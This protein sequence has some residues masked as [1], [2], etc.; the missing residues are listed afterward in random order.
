MKRRIE[1]AMTTDWPTSTPLMPAKMLIALVQNTASMPMYTK[2]RT[3][4]GAERAK[5]ACVGGRGAAT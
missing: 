4:R 2:Y 1:V 3:S 5:G